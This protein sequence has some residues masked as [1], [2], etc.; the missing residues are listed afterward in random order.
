M[1]SD[2]GADR[3]ATDSDTEM[4]LYCIHSTVYVELRIFQSLSHYTTYQGY[5]DT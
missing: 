1:P 2:V 5:F 4:Y 3:G